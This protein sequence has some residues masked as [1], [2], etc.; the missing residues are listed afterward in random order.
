M[1]EFCGRR[2]VK[3]HYAVL[4]TDLDNCLQRA[5]RRD[6]AEPA[7]L[8]GFRTLHSKFVDL[9]YREGHVLDASGPPEQVAQSVMS[10]FMSR[11]LL[12]DGTGAPP[13]GRNAIISPISPSFEGERHH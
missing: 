8:D 9:G 11:R 13:K 3:V 2:G 5:R 10:A 6:P 12:L 7:D 4:R 1:A